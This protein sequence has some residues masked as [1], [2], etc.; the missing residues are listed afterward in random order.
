MFIRLKLSFLG[1]RFLSFSFSLNFNAL[2]KY[3][4]NVEIGEPGQF[5]VKKVE[6]ALAHFKDRFYVTFK[7]NCLLRDE[8]SKPIYFN[9]PP[10]SEDMRFCYFCTR[11][12]VL[13]PG[14]L[15]LK[16]LKFPYQEFGKQQRM[17]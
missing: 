2:K 11:T 3:I 16:I 5:N 10:S 17:S 13:G 15:V 8:E 6:N 14:I 7:I 12:H 1:G 4:F 9:Y